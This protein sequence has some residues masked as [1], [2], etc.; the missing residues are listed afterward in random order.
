MSETLPHN[1]STGI[2]A[3]GVYSTGTVVYLYYL[4]FDNGTATPNID[5]S[6]DGTSFSPTG[7][8]FSIKTSASDTEDLSKCSDFRISKIRDQYVLVYKI[9]PNHQAHMCLAT[10]IDLVTWTKLGKISAN[11]EVSMVTPDTMIDDQ[12]VLFSGEKSIK[13]AFSHDMRHWLTEKNPIIARMPEHFDNAHLTVATIKR[14]DAG[15]VILYYVKRT[16]HGNHFYA[17]NTALVDKNN[18]RKL[19]WTSKQ[20][21]WEQTDHWT[22]KPVTPIGIA[23]LGSS[24]LSFWESDGSIF[25]I[26]HTPIEKILSDRKNI[27]FLFLKRIKENPI[28]K[29]IADHFWESK[30]VFNPAAIYEDGKVHL[31]YRAIGDHDRSMLGYAS[32]SDGVHIDERLAE[33]CYVPTEAFEG[34]APQFTTIPEGMTVGSYVSGGG[35]AGG[36][37]DPRLTKIGDTIYMTYVA[38]DG[39]SGPRVALT[40]IKSQDFV[41]KKWTWAKP[42]LISP[43]GVIDKNCVLFPEKINGKFVMYHRIY[44]N[45]LVDYLDDLDFDGETKFLKYNGDA[46]IHPRRTSWD[47]RKIGAGAPPIKTKYGWLLIYHSVGEQESN[48]YKMGAMILDQN[49]PSKVLF[50][51][52]NPIL[53]PDMHYENEGMKYG[54]AYPCGAAQV[55]DQ[56]FVYYGGADMVVC[57]AQAHMDEFL[58]ELVTHGTTHL[59]PVHMGL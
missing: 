9:N 15:I 38:Y 41:E 36:V 48:R 25:T 12:A 49:D 44:P 1:P 37:E 53:S 24:L 57:A 50:R 14:T 13:V 17:I 7:N 52:R 4:K 20:T 30:A 29:P 11:P 56:L 51:S 22:E 46:I 2:K 35:G 33:P 47:S 34:H 42:I 21:I 10:S 32:S 16:E 59:E 19:I 23:E 6:T 31:V 43:P 28:L 40:S 45:M 58:D 3:L 26:L 8:V 5:K 55:G 39:W 54:V 18:P 27:S